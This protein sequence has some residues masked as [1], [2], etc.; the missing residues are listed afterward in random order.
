[1]KKVFDAVMKGVL[2][3]KAVRQIVVDMLAA[4]TKA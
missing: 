3:G 1:M 4:M 2:D